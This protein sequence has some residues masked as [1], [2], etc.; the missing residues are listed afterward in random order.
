MNM[1]DRSGTATSPPAEA[2]AGRSVVAHDRAASPGLTT[3][4]AEVRRSLRYLGDDPANWVPRREGVDHDVVIIGGGQSGVAAAF[5]LR[6]AGIADVV[7]IDA[8]APGRAGTWV[9]KARMRTLRTPK[10]ITGPELGIPALSFPAWYEAQHGAA[11]YAAIGRISLEDWAAYIAWYQRMVGVVV[12][13]GTKLERIEPG[14]GMLRLHLVRD[15]QEGIM[16]ARKVVL[17]MGLLGA[18]VPNVLQ[19]S[20]NFLPRDRYAHTDDAIDFAA[21]RGRRVGV[22]GAAS[23]AFDAAGVALEAGA[24]EV[25][26]FCRG[27]DLA[28]V[29]REWPLG[30]PGAGDNFFHLPDADRWLLARVLRA[31][32]PGPMPETVRRATRFANFHLHLNARVH[33]GL[34]GEDIVVTTAGESFAMDFLIFGTGYIIDPTLQDEL[35]SFAHLIATWGDR[36]K[37]REHVENPAASRHPYVGAGFEFQ[38]ITPGAAPFLRNIHCFNFASIMSYGRTVG[39]IASLH[40]CVPRLVSA[41]SRDLFLDDRDHH[42]ARLTAKPPLELTGDEYQEAVWPRRARSLLQT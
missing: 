23:S 8:N 26:L 34:D 12:Q 32:S 40:S 42:M 14:A 36:S 38:E 5:A 13:Y 35:A 6:R 11:A 17:A 4:E 39:D 20:G 29:A 18:G 22:V 27:A 33:A 3:L 30:Y 10:R 19:G 41:I 2:A 24:A 7:V 15:G 21:M 28:H 16:T 1:Q 25:R 31:R 37:A 9:T